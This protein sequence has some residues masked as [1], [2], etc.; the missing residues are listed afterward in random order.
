MTTDEESSNIFINKTIDESAD[1]IN[2]EYDSDSYHSANTTP[3]N[4][5]VVK[6]KQIAC[7]TTNARSLLPKIDSLIDYFDELS[8]SF[9]V[10]C[11]TWLVDGEKLGDDLL[12]LEESSDL[13]M[14]FKN[15]PAKL[16]KRYKKRTA[17]GG[18]CILYDKNKVSIVEKKFPGNKFEIVCGIAS[19]PSMKR[20]IAICGVYLRPGSNADTNREALEFLADMIL[21][22]RTDFPDPFVMVAGDFNRVDPGPA[23]DDYVDM[24]LINSAPTRGDLFV[25][26]FVYFQS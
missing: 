21:K 23:I 22:I 1:D 18:V 26:L 10:V 4:F 19:V 2:S 9:A 7:L 16:T 25:C 12:D 24:S 3:K 14:I 17:G 8:A 6:Y 20:K 5:S 13:R 15:R 11:E